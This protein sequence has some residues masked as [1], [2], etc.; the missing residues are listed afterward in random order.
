M[1]SDRTVLRCSERSTGERTKQ[2]SGSACSASEDN[3]HERSAMDAAQSSD[4]RD[5]KILSRL[6]GGGSLV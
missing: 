6:P 2:A 5:E 1:E 4:L 3:L